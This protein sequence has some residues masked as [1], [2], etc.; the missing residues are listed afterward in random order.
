MGSFTIFK[1]GS[2]VS[3]KLQQVYDNLMSDPMFFTKQIIGIKPWAKQRKAIK[4]VMNLNGENHSRTAIKSCHGIGKTFIAGNIALQFLYTYK[5]SIVVTT[6]PTFRQVEKGIWKEIRQSYGM[7]RIP[8]GGKLQDGAPTLQI[9]KDQWYAFGLATSDS[10]KFQGLHEENIL[11]I[12]DEG[13]G[14]PE[15]IYNAIDGLLTSMNAKLLI[16]GNPTSITGTFKKAFSEPG[17]NK[18]SISAFDTPNFKYYNITEKEIA[19]GTWQAIMAAKNNWLPLPKLVTPAWVADKYKRWGPSSMLYKT[20][21]LGEFD[22]V[23][24]DTLIPLAWIE[25]AV[26]RNK[27]LRV[28]LNDKVSIGA[29]IA[30]FGRD[31][32]QVFVKTGRKVLSPFSFTKMPVMQLAGQLVLLYNQHQA[33]TIKIDTI[34]VGTGVEGR[35]DELGLNTIRVN[36]AEAPG[37][38]TEEERAKFINKRAQLYWALREQLDPDNI[39]AIGLPDDEELVEE[40]MATKFKVNSS[41][42]IQ[43][44]AKDEIKSEIGRSPDKADALMIACAPDNLLAKAKE[45][46]NAGVW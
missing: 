16:I 23:G 2:G 8:L 44:M 28:E 18:I 9:V 40:L 4:T 35:L 34:G 30:E 33:N 5:P 14:V 19:N 15:S 36:V 26:E 3:D 37:G 10:D 21:V 29:D 24:T 27:E 17:W 41:G 38:I 6:A 31:N 1:E 13:A 12:V 11:V 7:A 22:E 46:K 39:D 42:K 20:R 32:S 43:I 45:I 25:T